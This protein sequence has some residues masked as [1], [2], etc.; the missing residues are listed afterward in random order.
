MNKRMTVWSLV[1]VSMGVAAAALASTVTY[2]FDRDVDFSKWTFAAWRTPE[3]PGASMT[4]KRLARAVESGFAGRGYVLVAERPR[5]DFLIDYR[6]AA[7]QDVSL[8][9]NLGGPGFHR[10]ARVNREA[11][12][13]LVIDV[14]ER[15][16]GRLAW[17]GVVSDALADD[18]AEADRKTAKAVEKLLKKFPARGGGK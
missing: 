2:D 4:E 12:G 8:E 11:R 14:Y 9:G 3:R 15:A 6:A 10:Y 17:H 1:L 13:A 18:P 5:A 16:T 7:W